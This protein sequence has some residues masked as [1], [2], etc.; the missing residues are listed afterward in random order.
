[1]GNKIKINGEEFKIYDSFEDMYAFDGDKLIEVIQSIANINKEIE[2]D[3]AK[4]IIKTAFNT[5]I[6]KGKDNR[7]LLA[8]LIT[9]DDPKNWN[10]KKKREFVNTYAKVKHATKAIT[11]FLE[12]GLI[13]QVGSEMKKRTQSL[14]S[15]EK[16]KET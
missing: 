11:F 16:K 14:T 9:K 7:K 12:K 8:A 6:I 3:G 4:E 2:G 10:Y 1:M 5:G 13:E 15:Q